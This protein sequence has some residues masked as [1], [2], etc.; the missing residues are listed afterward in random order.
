[1]QQ[2]KEIKEKKVIKKGCG[3]ALS[4]SFLNL[5]VWWWKVKKKGKERGWIAMS[6]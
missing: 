6:T 4:F 3:R 1:L 5:F 2:R